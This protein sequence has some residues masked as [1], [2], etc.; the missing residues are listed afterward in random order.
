MS[1]YSQMLCGLGRV[2][3]FIG[4]ASHVLGIHPD[5]PRLRFGFLV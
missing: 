5:C 1:A 2:D 4:R 3:T